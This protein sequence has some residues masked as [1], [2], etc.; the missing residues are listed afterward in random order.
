MTIPP[1][2]AQEAEVVV[3]VVALPVLRGVGYASEWQSHE[4][5]RVPGAGR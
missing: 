4:L 2:G 3:V 5:A 1:Q